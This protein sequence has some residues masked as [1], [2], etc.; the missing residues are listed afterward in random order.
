MDTKGFAAQRM[1]LV[2][3]K[4][5]SRLCKKS[6]G[7][8]KIDLRVLN[9][10]FATANLYGYKR[11]CSTTNDACINEVGFTALQNVRRTCKN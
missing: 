2:S 3:M 9:R 7:L 11:L 5:G 10:K 1:M 4:L 6:E 8:A